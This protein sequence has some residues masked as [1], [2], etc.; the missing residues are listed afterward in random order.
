MINQLLT[1]TI[2]NQQ[3]EGKEFVKLTNKWE[4]H[5]QYQFQ[6]GLNIDSIPFKP[7]GE[8]QPGGIYFCLFED[9]HLWLNYNNVD[10]FYARFVTIPD[11][12]QVWTEVGERSSPI[13]GKCIAITKKFKA[14][15]LILG[16]RQQIVDLE[17]WKEPA[18]CLKVVKYDFGLLKYVKQQTVEICLEAVR[19]NGGALKYV[20]EQT[21]QICLA[22][23]RN[24]GLALQYVKQQ[25]EEICLA[26]VKNRGWV[27]KYVKQQTQEI[28]LAAVKN[29]ANGLQYVRQQT[30]QICLGYG[31]SPQIL[32]PT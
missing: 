23:V 10:M 12:A 11:D 14:D 13:T 18:Y 29:D 7:Q 8:C 32:Q 15:R 22:A 21:L 27:L 1:G 9:L 30:P 28:N 17:V 19:T 26:A 4:N 5:N 2:F 16:D 24:N 3:Y 31:G 6:T 20:V 25:T